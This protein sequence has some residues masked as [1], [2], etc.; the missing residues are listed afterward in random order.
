MVSKRTNERICA[1]ETYRLLTKRFIGILRKEQ[2]LK[3]KEKALKHLGHYLATIIPRVTDNEA[4]VR[5]LALDTIQMLLF[6]DQ[7]LRN[8]GNEKPSD[9][10]RSLNALKKELKNEKI[11]EHR[12]QKMYYLTEILCRLTSAE[13]MQSLLVNLIRGVNDDDRQSAL[14]T[15]KALQVSSYLDGC[16][17]M[18]SPFVT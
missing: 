13:E 14:G 10:L 6:V 4:K 12:L 11:A 15:C 18:Y 8:P 9:E 1:L 5:E 16:W 2:D 7:L 17:C 3:G